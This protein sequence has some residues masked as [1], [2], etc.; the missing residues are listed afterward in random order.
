VGVH[1][2]GHVGVQGPRQQVVGG[3]Q[4]RDLATPQVGHG[5]RG[6]QAHQAA[7][8]HQGAADGAA[9]EA[10][11]Q[12]RDV[13]GRLGG[14]HRAAEYHAF[15]HHRIAAQGVDQVIVHVHGAGVVGQ[16][17]DGHRSL[18]AV[19]GLDLA[20]AEHLDVAGGREPGRVAERAV[21]GAAQV[22]EAG[23]FAA[24]HVRQA[25]GAIADEVGA[26]DH[27]DGRRWQQSAGPRGGLEAGR[28][29]AEHD[30]A[31]LGHGRLPVRAWTS[32]CR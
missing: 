4:H 17:V 18:V 30:D 12:V 23:Q 22:V 15:R 9:L 20:A 19:D 5:G 7:A 10:A 8:Q 29:G 2:A 21:A 26:V 25:A 13:A 32:P 6:L 11:A 27:R 28:A 3:L 16:A 31:L 1:Q 14:A 24:Q